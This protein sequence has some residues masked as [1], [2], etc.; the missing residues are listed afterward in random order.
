MAAATKTVVNGAYNYGTGDMYCGQ[1]DITGRPCGKGILYYFHSGEADVAMFDGSLNQKGEGVRYTAGRDAAYRLVDGELEGGSLDLEEALNLMGLKD[2]P[3]I[4]FK[5]TIP[6][7]KGYDPAR[8][9]QTQAFYHYRT[10]CG[11]P[12][13]ESLYGANPYDPIWVN[14]KEDEDEDEE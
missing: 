11:L 13:N 5:D 6:D 9:R 8:H 10:M 3:A 14:R 4:R 7:S 12:C 1:L 2:T